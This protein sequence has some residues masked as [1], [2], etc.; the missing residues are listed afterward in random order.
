MNIAYQ[1]K[2]K[3]IGTRA[4]D[5]NET[6][7]HELKDCPLCGK[8]SVFWNWF[9]KSDQCFNP[10]CIAFASRSEVDNQNQTAAIERGRLEPIVQIKSKWATL[11]TGILILLGTCLI[12][13]GLLGYDALGTSSVIVV[14]AS[15][16]VT[17]W[18]L[19]T[20]VFAYKERQHIRFAEITVP[21]VATA[22]MVLIEIA[23]GFAS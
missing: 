16:V 10:E 20:L 14:A 21:S 4:E 2:E 15:T 1:L 17:T 23:F 7:F 8:T 12:V 3:G 19:L 6:I 5:M 22:T 11:L 9:T 13:Y 18:S